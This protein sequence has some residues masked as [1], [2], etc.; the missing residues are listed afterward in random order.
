MALQSDAMKIVGQLLTV[1]S[2]VAFIKCSIVAGER[3]I[4]SA[5]ERKRRNRGAQPAASEF[6]AHHSCDRQQKSQTT[7]PVQLEDLVPH[8]FVQTLPSMHAALS[9]VELINWKPT[10]SFKTV[11][12]LPYSL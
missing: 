2:V 7:S 3:P 10:V 6:P 5:N 9:F 12:P 4:E 11:N 1:F 8:S